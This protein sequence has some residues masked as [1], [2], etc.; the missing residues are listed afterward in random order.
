MRPESDLRIRFHVVFPP[1]YTYMIQ[2]QS[3]P[4]ERKKFEIVPLEPCSVNTAYVTIENGFLQHVKVISCYFS[5]DR[6]KWVMA[7]SLVGVLGWTRSTDLR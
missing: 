5:A 7:I 2:I 4:H 6:E 3:M 1:A